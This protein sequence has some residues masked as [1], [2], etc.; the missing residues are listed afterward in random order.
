MTAS[1]FLG[2]RTVI[3]V[4][5]YLPAISIILPFEPMMSSKSEL[6]L[7]LKLA[8]G[9]VESH[10]MARYPSEKAMPALFKLNR[11][12]DN[13]NYNT[14]KK[15]I[16]IFVSPV[17]E[18]VYYLDIRVEEKIVFDESFEIRDLIY[19]KKQNTDYLVLILSAERSKMFLNNSSKFNL[20]KSNI[21]ENVF[22]CKHDKAEKATNFSDTEKYKEVL[23]Y[24]FLH[25]MDEGL[26]LVLKAYN[27]PVFVMGAEKVLGH[28]KKNSQNVD[29]LVEF[30]HGNYTDATDSEIREALQPYVQDWK[31]IKQHE[32]IMEIAK[33]TDDGK[34]ASGIHKVW[35]AVLHKNCRLLVVEKDFVCPVHLGS[36]TDAI[37]KTGPNNPFYIKDAVDEIMEKVLQS[38]GNVEFVENDLLIDYGR[39]AL[40][41]YH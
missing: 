12:I 3:D 41:Q 13:I 9:Q 30:I 24:K 1:T 39:I 26:T 22:A 36:N 32:I 27:L 23:L 17:T 2:G 31:N 10:L 33:A 35:K 20:I 8:L 4:P 15:S 38:G 16:A 18:K 19:S 29:R 34:V 21:R 5:H 7:K 6:G 25:H 11:V 14:H 37:H 40:I 28:F